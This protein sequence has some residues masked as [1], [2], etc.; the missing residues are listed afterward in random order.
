MIRC[1]HMFYIMKKCRFANTPK[2]LPF[3]S[4]DFLSETKNLGQCSK[5]LTIDLLAM[6]GKNLNRTML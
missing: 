2:N 6:L 4:Q 5:F 1:V 3:Y